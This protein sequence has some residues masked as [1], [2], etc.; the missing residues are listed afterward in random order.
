MKKV[1][2]LALSIMVMTFAFGS[3]NS[4]K[5]ID[6]VTVA[7]PDGEEKTEIKAIDLPKAIRDVLAS[8]DYRGWKS[9]ENA[10]LVKKKDGTEFYKITLKNPATDESKTIKMDKNGNEIKK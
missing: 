7:S 5:N 3:A 8:S 10:Y 4:W 1:F 6:I 2:F 9:E